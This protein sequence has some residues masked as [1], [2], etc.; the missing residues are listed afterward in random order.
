[1]QVLV[2]R[3]QT[4]PFV[5]YRR[6]VPPNVAYVPCWET[7]DGAEFPALTSPSFSSAALLPEAS[8]LP[9]LHS[10]RERRGKK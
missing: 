9:H 8:L 7:G 2:P 5:D 4:L 10:A 6:N 3:P 1:M